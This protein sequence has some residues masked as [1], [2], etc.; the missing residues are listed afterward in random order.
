MD[1]PA[2]LNIRIIMTF[3]KDNLDDYEANLKNLK[4]ALLNKN[5][6]QKKKKAVPPTNPVIEQPK[7][8]TRNP[9]VVAREKVLEGYPAWKRNSVLNMEETNNKND[10]LYEAFVLDVSAKADELFP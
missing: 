9:F 7:I 3:N 6:I 4:K 1:L 10:R 2:I 5:N 8:E